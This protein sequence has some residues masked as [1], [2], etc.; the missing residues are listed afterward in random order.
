[1]FTD[2]GSKGEELTVLEVE[3][4]RTVGRVVGCK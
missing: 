3:G 2:E 1:M 4:A